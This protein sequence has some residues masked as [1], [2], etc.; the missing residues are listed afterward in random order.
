MS[1]ESST[2]VAGYNY[3]N[4]DI[5]PTILKDDSSSDIGRV[6]QGSDWYVKHEDERGVFNDLLI[7]HLPAIPTKKFG[8]G[9]QIINAG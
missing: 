9:I 2:A 4:K 3:P 7:P 5:E 1:T 8:M 6:M